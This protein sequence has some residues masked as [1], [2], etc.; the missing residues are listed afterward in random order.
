LGIAVPNTPHCDRSRPAGRLL[1]DYKQY[2]V[3]VDPYFSQNPCSHSPCWIF[4]R[5]AGENDRPAEVF[6]SLL[7]E[8]IVL[9]KF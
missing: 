6:A 5:P 8:I 9:L 4:G 2:L 7:V 1:P 3:K